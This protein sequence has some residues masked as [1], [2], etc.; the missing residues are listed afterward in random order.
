MPG[1]RRRLG[2]ELVLAGIQ[3]S[4]SGVRGVWSRHVLLSKHGLLMQLEKP[5][6][7]RVVQR[8]MK[9]RWRHLNALPE[10][11]LNFV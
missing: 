9:S 4:S 3:V 2:G 6:A 5:S 7:D 10:S 11:V 1:K 8:S